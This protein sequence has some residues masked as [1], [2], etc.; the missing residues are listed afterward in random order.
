MKQFIK[1]QDYFGRPVHLLLDGDSS[2]NTFCGG[3]MSLLL[4]LFMLGLTVY[5]IYVMITY[6][7]DNITTMLQENN[8]NDPVNWNQT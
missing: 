8:S 7:N 3:L 6:S 1:N 4:K 5:K 2:H